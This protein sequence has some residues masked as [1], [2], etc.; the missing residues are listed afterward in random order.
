MTQCKSQKIGQIIVL[1]SRPSSA[2]VILA[3]I[4]WARL[5]SNS[6]NLPHHLAPPGKGWL[7]GFPSRSLTVIIPKT[8]LREHLLREA[9]PNS[10][11]S[12]SWPPLRP[13]TDQGRLCPPGSA[14]WFIPS[15]ANEEAPGASLGQGLVHGGCWTKAKQLDPG[16]K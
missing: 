8:Q 10:L 6:W 5:H 12:Q 2:G 11:Y 16:M 14:G 7:F 1:A 3:R 13:T 4:W 9:F 15:S